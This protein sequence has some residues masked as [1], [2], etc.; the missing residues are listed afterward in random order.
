MAIRLLQ[1]VCHVRRLLILLLN[2]EVETLP[3]SLS[4]A[5]SRMD[6][7]RGVLSYREKHRSDQS[8]ADLV[9]LQNAID[10]CN[11]TPA[12]QSGQTSACPYLTTIPSSTASTCKV[13]QPHVS[14]PVTG[15][16]DKLAGCN[17]VQ[18]GPGDAILYN[19]DN[20]PL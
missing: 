14:E 20:C 2:L 12:Q 13:A 9:A 8:L 19:D 18:A 11:S 1:W 16:L 7:V 4:M 6:G 10:N 15:V 5:N 17:P 3:D